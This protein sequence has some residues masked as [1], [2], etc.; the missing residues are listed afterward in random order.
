MTS[1]DSISLGIDRERI[2]KLDEIVREGQNPYPY[3]Y[4]T[5]HDCLADITDDYKGSVRVAGRVR[6][7]RSFGKLTFAHIQHGTNRIQIA[8]DQTKVG[9]G[10]YEKFRRRIDLGDF[11]GVEGQ[12]FRTKTQELTVTVSSYELL[13]KSLRTIPDKWSKLKDPEIRFRQRY[14]DLM[15]N[16][17]EV[18]DIFI[19]RSRGVTAM[20]EF[21]DRQGYL[22]VETP[23]VVDIYGGASARPFVTSVNALGGQKAYLSIAPELH[24]KRLIVGG[25]PAVYTICKNFRN[26]GIDSTHNPEFTMMECYRA[27]VDYYDMMDLTEQ[28]YAY[29]F[30]RVL[31]T[32]IVEY[33]GWENSKHGKVAI[34]FAPPWRRA[35]LT[36]LVMESTGLNVE[37]MDD[38]EIKA[39]IKEKGPNGNTYLDGDFY[40]QWT[41]GEIVEELFDVYVADTLVQPTFV[42]DYPKES[43]PLCKV[44]RK[45]PR[46]IERFEPHVYGI[47]IGNAYSEL[48]DPILQRELLLENSKRAKE[49]SNAVPCVP[50]SFDED[51]CVSIEYGMPPTGGLGLGVD[52]MAMFLTGSQSIKDVI[53]YPFMKNQE[54][55]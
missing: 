4:E 10:Q 13:A 39:K 28:M 19:K 43:T 54:Q 9:L 17:P 38:D 31:G 11:I 14:L 7:I 48:N 44:H 15:G 18:M 25:F 12:L 2:K 32:T 6:S 24:L 45:N 16:N 36:D 42:T 1:Q 41:W 29:I 49:L 51:F 30:N 22:E 34:N 37:S 27:F 40:Q 26:E 46:L 53:L 35:R 8:L 21:L 52:R 33:G 47:E 23:V 55:A 50:K 3:R 5:T 20:R